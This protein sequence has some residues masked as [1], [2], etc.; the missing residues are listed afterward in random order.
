MAQVPT[1]RGGSASLPQ[2]IT[3]DQKIVT[4][5]SGGVNTSKP[6][7]QIGD[8]ESPDMVNLVYVN[9]VLCVDF[10]YRAMG[11]PV[12]GW[13]MQP[14]TFVDVFGIEHTILVTT[15]MVYLWMEGITDW[16]P[17]P[18]PMVS[19]ARVSGDVVGDG[20]APTINFTGGAGWAAF[21]YVGI[22]AADGRWYVSQ[23]TGDTTPVTFSDALP[24]GMTLPDNAV[25]YKLPFFTS[26][27]S[28]PV[29][30]VYDPQRSTV[31]FCNGFDPVQDCDTA[32]C[33][34][35]A[36][37]DLIPVETAGYI[38]RF[39]G[40][41]VLGNV[42]E[43]GSPFPYR[44]RRSATGDSTNWTTLN[45]GFD[46]LIDTNDAISG[47]V[48]VN[49]NMIVLRRASIMRASYYGVGLQVFWYDYALDS[50]GTIGAQGFDETK[51]ASVIVSESGIYLYSGDY[52]LRNIGE[53]IFDT[54]LSYSGELNPKSQDLLFC[55]YVPILDETWIFYPDMR[56]DFS[57]MIWRYSHRRNAWFKRKFG[58]FTHWLGAGFFKPQVS[59]RWLDLVGTRWIDRHK[60]WNA[61]SSLQNYHGILLCGQSPPQVFLYDF[62]RTT[63]DDG[64]PIPWRFVSK[65]YPIPANWTTIDSLTF[66]GKGIVNLVEISIDYG[67]TWR[68]LA[69]DVLLGPT[70]KRADAFCVVTCE[71]IRLRFSGDDPSFKL[72]WFAFN[73]MTASEH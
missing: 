42:T 40:I 27:G 73:T 10:G 1:F 66:Y 68:E 47:L 37:L 17:I 20:T 15:Q 44:I 30:W 34:P 24:V 67:V 2:M 14:I 25:M 69:R 19:F 32:Q 63:T 46:D 12:L 61:R 35:L 72:S 65:D 22:P 9:K 21:D 13:P 31:L 38:A 49:P 54:L 33:G 18:A 26:D 55:M 23:S 29:S 53:N 6:P 39:H 43:G 58:N 4:D 62:N 48:I 45:S 8:T 28:K 56:S 16:V 60:P 51:T 59:N 64:F 36:G 11:S 41:T 5:L 71:F 50:T 7:D 52:G 3:P 57:N 70:W